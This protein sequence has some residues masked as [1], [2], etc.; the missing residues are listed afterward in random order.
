[1]TLGLK[2]GL[3]SKPFHFN[4]ILSE[5]KQQSFLQTAAKI[6]QRHLIDELEHTSLNQSQKQEIVQ[7]IIGS[8][9]LAMVS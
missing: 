8:A 9:V 3:K 1:M 6:F 7:S 5:D 2:G 4:Q